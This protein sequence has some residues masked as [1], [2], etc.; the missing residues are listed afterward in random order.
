[1]NHTLLQAICRTN[2]IY[3][4]A[5][6]HGLIVDYIGIFDDVAKALNFDENIVQQVI[7]NIAELKKELPKLMAK[8]L[9]YFNGVD[10]TVEGW[11]GLM[12][13]QECLSSNEVKDAFGADYKVLNRVWEALSPDAFL[14]SYKFDYLWL[15]KGHRGW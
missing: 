14:A 12:A 11:E 13:A 6:T 4:N 9:I 8:C 5:K 1:M 7:S 10:R 15:T 3:G 2:R